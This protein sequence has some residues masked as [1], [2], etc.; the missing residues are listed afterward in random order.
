MSRPVRPRVRVSFGTKVAFLSKRQIAR[1]MRAPLGRPRVVA[2]WAY[3][4]ATGSKDLAVK[5]VD[6]VVFY[7]KKRFPKARFFYR[8]FPP[9]G[10]ATAYNNRTVVLVRY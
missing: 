4:D 9:K 2:V 1:L 8:T 6:E 3:T 5:R 10:K 7:L